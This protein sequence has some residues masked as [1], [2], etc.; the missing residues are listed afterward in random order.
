MMCDCPMAGYCERHKMNKTEKDHALCNTPDGF[1]FFEIVR[2]NRAKK[3]IVQK[4]VS[5]GTAVI[6][7]VLN[8]QV[9]ATPDTIKT[10]LDICSACPLLDGTRHCMSCGCPVDSKVTF[11]LEVCPEGKWGA[12]TT[13]KKCG[14]CGS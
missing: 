2:G 1:K 14:S 5:Y 9:P 13:G 8:G 10:R 6:K 4:V 12:E 11:P 3:N 7:D